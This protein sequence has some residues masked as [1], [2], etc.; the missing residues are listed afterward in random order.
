MALMTTSGSMPFSFASASMV[1]CNGFDMCCFRLSARGF[2]LELHFQV[3]PCNQVHRHSV[4]PSIVGFDEHF[5]AVEAAEPP[6]EKPL[7][8]DALAH[9]HFGASAREATVVVGPPQRPI[10]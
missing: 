9:H 2:Q 3:R 8:V 5:R 4:R 7:T 1:C 6:L 10:Q